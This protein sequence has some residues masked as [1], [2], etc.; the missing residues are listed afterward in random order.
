MGEGALKAR[1]GREG[2]AVMV[3]VLSLLLHGFFGI[4]FLD[5]LETQDHLTFLKDNRK[6]FF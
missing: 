1:A 5:T 2:N 4:V 6:R 3:A